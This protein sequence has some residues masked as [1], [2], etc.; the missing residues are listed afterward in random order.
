MLWRMWQEIDCRWTSVGQVRDLLS[1]AFR[2]APNISSRCVVGVMLLRLSVFLQYF[3][4]LKF[5]HVL[6]I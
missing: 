5:C 3:I 4:K 6:Y 2:E 1:N